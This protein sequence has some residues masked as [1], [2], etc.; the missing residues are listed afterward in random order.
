MENLF[1][2]DTN[3]YSKVTEARICYHSYL[4]SKMFRIIKNIF[5]GDT[6]RIHFVFNTQVAWTGLLF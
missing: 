6:N 3:P 2:R 1:F 4:S 5:N